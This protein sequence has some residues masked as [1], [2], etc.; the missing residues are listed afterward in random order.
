MIKTFEKP[1]VE[2]SQ[3]L[4]FKHAKLID[5]EYKLSIDDLNAAEK[6]ELISH[7]IKVNANVDAFM[8]EYLNDA[9]MDRNYAEMMNLTI[10]QEQRDL[11]W[12]ERE[13]C[14]DF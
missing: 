5:N 6:L 14:Y 11:G 1:L 2:L 3:S 8:Q 12:N 13:G 4:A 10:E 9:C 7:F